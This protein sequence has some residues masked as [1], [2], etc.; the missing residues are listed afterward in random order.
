ML[1][2]C[3]TPG[4]AGGEAR[5]VPAGLDALAAGLEA[6]E[7]HAGVVEEAV[8]D[9]HRVGAAADAG[10]DGVGQPAGRARAPAA[11]ASSPM[12]LVEVADHLG[13]RVRAGDGAE[14]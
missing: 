9:A 11:R 5:R 1:A 8:E 10:D 14:R 6:D 4:V 7:P 13:E 12:T 2:P 3:S